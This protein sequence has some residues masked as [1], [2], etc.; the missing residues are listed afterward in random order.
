MLFTQHWYN[1]YNYFIFSRNTIPGTTMKKHG[2]ETLVMFFPNCW[3]SWWGSSCCVCHHICLLFSCVMPGW[4]KQYW[5]SSW[6]SITKAGSSLSSV[7]WS[8]KVLCWICLG[9]CFL[10]IPDYLR[11]NSFWHH[12]Q[13]P[14]IMRKQTLHC[15]KLFSVQLQSYCVN[16]I[17]GSRILH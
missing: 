8:L 4:Q 10:C 5:H 14:I 12:L 16:R 3:M 9:L 15:F 6:G 13:I 11:D 2:P 7:S 1:N 17:S